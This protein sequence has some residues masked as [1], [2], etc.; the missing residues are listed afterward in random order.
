MELSNLRFFH[1]Q[2][3]LHNLSALTKTPYQNKYAITLSELATQ[4]TSL[5]ESVR[6]RLHQPQDEATYN[7]FDLIHDHS[8]LENLALQPAFQDYR[9][10]SSQ[11][12]SKQAS[13]VWKL[14]RGSI[15]KVDRKTGEIF[16]LCEDVDIMPSKRLSDTAA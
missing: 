10:L 6:I 8:S 13:G 15:E 4:Y 2:T 1:T 14:G 7:P 16:H 11:A 9:E 5:A 3:W 12:S